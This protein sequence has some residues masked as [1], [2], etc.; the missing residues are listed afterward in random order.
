MKNRN[1]L[2][3]LLLSVALSSVLTLPGLAQSDAKPFLGRWS[4]YL[5]G[6]AGWLNVH[7]DHGYLDAELLWYGGSVLP[8]ANA[9]I[10]SD[11]ALVVTRVDRIERDMPE[12]RTHQLTQRFVL[13]PG[14][15]ELTGKAYLPNADGMGEN[16]VPIKAKKLPDLPSAPNVAAATFGEPIKLFNGKDLTGWR[17]ID[18][19]HKN[20]WVVEN[21][22]LINDPM[23]PVEDP[24]RYHYGNLR[25]E[26]TFEDFNLKLE[27]NN[28]EGSNSGVYLRGLYEIQVVDSY[29]KDLDPHNMGA[30]YSRVTPSEPAEKAPGEWQTMDITLYNHHVTVLLNGKKIL[31]NKPVLGVTGG[32]MT[33]DEFSPG[34]IYLQGDHGK[35]LYRNIVLT[36]INE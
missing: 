16:I 7:N 2:R 29:G 14:A 3:A 9:Y 27:V 24:H 36:P 32:A 28:P 17:L 23:Q 10:A 1:T 19:E 6:G 33:A 34:P 31:D 11:G 21:G 15:D 26:D 4:L 8:V 18:P 22:V 5:P 30:L 20:G 13:Q 25:T 12:E 35:V